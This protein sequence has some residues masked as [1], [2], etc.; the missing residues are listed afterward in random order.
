[1]NTKRHAGDTNKSVIIH[2]ISD[3]HES[4]YKQRAKPRSKSHL[5][6]K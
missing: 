4:K 5:I 6:K 2:H 1:M 3:Q